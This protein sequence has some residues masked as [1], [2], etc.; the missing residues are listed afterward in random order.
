MD[1]TRGG[2]TVNSNPSRLIVSTNIPI[3]SEH[4]YIYSQYIVY[5]E[6]V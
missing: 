1:K 4:R 3:H 2:D 6:I 5:I